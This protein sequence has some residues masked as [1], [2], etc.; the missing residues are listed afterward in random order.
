MYNVQ[1]TIENY[2]ELFI[3][4]IHTTG[5]FVTIFPTPITH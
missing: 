4:D 2:A 1:C 3:I 5:L